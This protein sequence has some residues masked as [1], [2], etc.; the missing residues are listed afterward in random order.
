MR[1]SV[2]F[3]ALAI[4]TLTGIGLT[5]CSRKKAVVAPPAPSQ[6]VQAQPVAQPSAAQPARHTSYDYVKK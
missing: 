2:L 3:G 6:V 4:I 1:K 5:A